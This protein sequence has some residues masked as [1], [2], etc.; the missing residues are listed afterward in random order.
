MNEISKSVIKIK[1]EG[2]FKDDSK[3]LRIELAKHDY[4]GRKAKVYITGKNQALLALV[5]L[6]ELSYCDKIEFL[7][8]EPKDKYSLNPNV[9]V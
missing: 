4:T 5:V 8:D 3:Q 6:E 2:S 7:G 9:E 1:G